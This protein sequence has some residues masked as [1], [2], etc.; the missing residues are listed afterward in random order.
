VTSKRP[1]RPA[2]LITGASAGIGAALAPLFAA[3]GYDLVLVAR[4]KRPLRLLASQ[5]QGAHG[6]RSTVIAKDL[7]RPSAARELFQAVSDVHIEVLVN[8]AGC[9]EVGRFDALPPERLPAMIQ[10]N[11]TTV[12]SLTRLF[13]PS[14]VKRNA[15]RILNV[16]S[17]AAFQTVPYLSLYAATKAFVLSLSE[18]LVEELR[19]TNV[20]VTALCPGITATEGVRRARRESDIVGA[21]P[22]LAVS[23]EDEVVRAGFRAC[24]AGDPLC[25]PG[26]VNAFGTS[27]NRVPRTVA[28]MI[29][30]AVLRRV[31]GR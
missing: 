31:V 1:A 12:A 5:L 14:M 3:A 9:Y 23:D 11:C 13:L 26:V 4:R 29:S 21:V 30:G 7:G 2:A 28:R 19:D 20:T 6:A 10:L 15:G 17:V 22:E 18:G 24:M 8:N 16:A 27:V 25:V